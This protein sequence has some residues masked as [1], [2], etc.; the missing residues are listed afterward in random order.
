MCTFTESHHEVQTG[1]HHEHAPNTCKL[2]SKLQINNVLVEI[3]NRVWHISQIFIHSCRQKIHCHWI[4]LTKCWSS[5]PV[6]IKKISDSHFPFLSGR[7]ISH[8]SSPHAHNLL[9][10]CHVCY[11]PLLRSDQRSPCHPQKQVWILHRGMKS[12]EYLV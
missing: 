10:F 2:W 11:R 7:Q 1:S 3:F 6:H 8:Q 4:L 5:K 9:P 12:F